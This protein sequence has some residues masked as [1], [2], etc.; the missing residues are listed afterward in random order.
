MLGVPLAR[1]RERIG[2]E[3]DLL[4]ACFAIEKKRFPESMEGRRLLS[5]P[6]GARRG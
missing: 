6:A 4:Q 5:G 2:V 3:V 1:V